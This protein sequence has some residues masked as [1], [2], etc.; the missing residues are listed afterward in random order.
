MVSGEGVECAEL[1]EAC[2]YF[3]SGVAS[4]A[5]DVAADHLFAPEAEEEVADDGEAQ[6]GEVGVVVACPV[7]GVAAAA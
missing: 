5:A 6:E 3:F 1:E 2:A 7:D 4:E